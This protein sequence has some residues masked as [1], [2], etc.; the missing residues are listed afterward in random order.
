MTIW[1]CI[2][3]NYLK[4]WNEL[5]CCYS[6]VLI[7]SVWILCWL[8]YYR[9]YGIYIYR[10]KDNITPLKAKT[11]RG[12]CP[13]FYPNGWYSLLNSNELKKDEVRYINYCGR[14]I[15]LFRGT[16]GTVYALHAYCAHMGANLGVGGKVKHQRCIQCPFHGWMFDGES[17]QAV[18]SENMVKKTVCQ[19]E[20]NNNVCAPEEINGAYL[21]KSYEGDIKLKTYVVKEVNGSILIWFDSREKYQNNPHYE[22]FQFESDLQFRGESINYVNCH[23][24]EIPENGADVRHFDFLHT[25]MFDYIKFIRFEWSMLSHRANEKGL[26]ETMRHKNQ[27]ID[28]YKSF[29]LSK[30]INEENKDFLNIISLD[31]YVRVFGWRFFFFNATGFQLGPA[32]VYLFL[33]S[34]F[35]EVRF[36]Q[37]ITPLDKFRIK[38]SHK[39]FTNWYLPYWL[40]AWMLYA[41]VKQ[42]FSDMLIWNNKTFG[43]TLTYNMR[44]D[45]DRI[46]HSWR[47]WYAQF[48]EGCREFE[49]KQNILNW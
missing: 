17:G 43:S 40:T 6:L 23:I 34:Y 16:N 2:T 1:S 48:Y 19:Y 37:S 14:D 49:K 10:Q 13:P 8:A 29:T 21:K 26:F 28:D 32:L 3:E 12:K 47:N 27:F 11:A 42:L 22:P 20:Y 25:S 24:Q 5:D 44:T 35:F 4:L 46:L 15:A 33:R 45:A 41:E 36:A 18:V 38:V 39:I 7:A 31:C 9:K 30:Y